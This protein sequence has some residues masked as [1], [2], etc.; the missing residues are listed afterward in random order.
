MKYSFR[1]VFSVGDV[2]TAD[3]I[4]KM[5]SYNGNSYT[6]TSAS[7][8]ITLVED[9]DANVITLRSAPP[10]AL[11]RPGFPPRGSQPEE[12]PRPGRPPIL[13]IEELPEEGGVLKLYF[14]RKDT[15][16]TVVHQYYTNGSLTSPA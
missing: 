10:G 9:A 4:S 11:P 1:T 16:Y 2:V 6:Y 12:H 7:G 13:S 5:T 14:D 15:T 3:S 8:S